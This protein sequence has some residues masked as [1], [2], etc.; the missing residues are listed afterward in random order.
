M[1]WK[2]FM[3]CA[4]ST[5]YIK[6][7]ETEAETLAA[8]ETF[9][10]LSELPNI[11]GA[12]DGSHIRIKAPK[13]NVWF[14]KI[15]IPPTEG[16]STLT[17]PPGFSV[18]EGLAILPHP[19]EIPRFS[20]WPP[21]PWK[22]HFYKKKNEIRVIYINFIIIYLKCQNVLYKWTKTFSTAHFLRKFKLNIN[23]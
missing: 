22:I 13:N 4:M 1:W 12:I 17:P 10:E 14:Q 11:V 8:T 16:F 23:I 9:E 6:F 21:T 3:N 20:T 15:S 19:P 7:P 18:P 5:R 2:P